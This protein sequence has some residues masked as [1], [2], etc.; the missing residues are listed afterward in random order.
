MFE[1]GGSIYMLGIG[2]DITNVDRIAE[3]SRRYGQ[4]FTDKMLAE[5]ESFGSMESLAGL[6]A[7]KEAVVKAMGTGYLGF[8]PPSVCIMPDAFGAPQVFL[9]GQAAELAR[10]RGISRFLVTISHAGGLAVAC[11]VAL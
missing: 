1:W 8:G 6:W 3:L 2:I 9:R 4:R 7:A 11:A 10:Q 5:G